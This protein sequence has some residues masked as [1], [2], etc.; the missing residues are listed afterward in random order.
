MRLLNG[1]IFGTGLGLITAAAGNIA[2]GYTILLYLG[3]AALL[4]IEIVR[5]L[6]RT[7]NYKG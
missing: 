1:L 5:F 2:E 6:P 3:G 7:K 4:T